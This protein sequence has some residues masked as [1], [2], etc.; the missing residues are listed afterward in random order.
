MIGNLRPDQAERVLCEQMHDTADDKVITKIWIK[1]FAIA[2]VFLV[3]AIVLVC[4][5]HDNNRRWLIFSGVLA[6][7][8]IITARF[9][10]VRVIAPRKFRAQIDLYGRENLLAQMTAED[11]EAFFFDPAGEN[12]ENIAVITR[13]YLILSREYIFEIN[14]LKSIFFAKRVNSESALAKFNDEY[15]REVMR[16][17]Y[18]MSVTFLNGKYRK[19]YIAVP[20][21]HMEYFLGALNRRT[22]T[23]DNRFRMF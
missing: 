17:L 10:K 22:W 1:N 23:D 12:T 9:L 18:Q 3:L 7:M 2:G 8:M 19:M 6:L 13:D 14:A 21:E 5:D 20:R 11:S 15:N 4:L 16:N